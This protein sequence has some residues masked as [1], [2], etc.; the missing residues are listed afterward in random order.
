[1]KLKHF[2]FLLL[3]LYQLN[4]Q[5]SID[6]LYMAPIEKSIWTM[7]KDSVLLCQIE[8]DIPKIGKA[9]FYQES[10]KK[11][12]FKL[13]SEYRYQKG[14]DVDIQSITANWKERQSA[15]KLS[16]VKTTGNNALIKIEDTVARQAYYELQQG[17]HLDLSFVDDEDGA[18]N[19]SIVVSTVNF[20]Q[21]EKKF[22]ACVMALHP[23]SF[24][25][26][27]R[28]LVHFDFDEEFPKIEEEDK[29]LKGMLDYL[30]VDKGVKTITVT[31]HTDYKGSICYND[32]L[33]SRRAMY[34]YDFL[35]QSDVDPKKLFLEF[36]GE[37]APLLKKKDDASRAKNRRVEVILNK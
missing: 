32:T 1:M 7:T 35:L 19:V 24:D 21:V 23:D 16:K 11:I 27:K 26:I 6:R 34:V 28:A 15:A 4:S 8:H 2:T 12:K 17:Y 20:R 36:K 5:A 31:G 22:S 3:C 33:S 37:S 14:L 29:S 25:D 30:K 9:V 10:G 18:N 13:L